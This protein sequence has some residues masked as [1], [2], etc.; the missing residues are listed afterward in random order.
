MA[1]LDKHKDKAEEEFKEPTEVE[2]EDQNEEAENPVETSSDDTQAEEPVA[3]KAQGRFRRL[4]QSR[5]FRIA[6]PIV[7]LV[8]ILA[9]FFVPPVKYA[10]LNLFSNGKAQ[11]VVVDDATLAPVSGAT[12]KVG[13]V[14]GKTDKNG[15]LTLKGLDFGSQTYILTKDSYTTKKA[16]FTVKTGDNLVGPVKVHSDGFAVEVRAVNKLSGAK[17]ADFAV[18]IDGTN[19]SAQS[20]KAGVATLKVPSKRLGKQTLAIT[21]KGFNKLTVET[22]VTADKQVP[23]SASLTLAGKH[24]FL[25]NRDGRMSIYSANLDGSDQTEVIK[26][27]P[28]D[29]TA[30]SFTSSPDGKYGVMLSKRDQIR[31][32][33][34]Q[35][36]SALYAIDYSAKTIK[37]VDEGAPNFSIS[38]WAD[39]TRAV[40]TVDY[41][42]AKRSDNQKIKTVDVTNGKLSTIASFGGYPQIILFREYPQYVYVSLPDPGRPDY[43]LFAYNIN[44]KARTQLESIGIGTFSQYKPGYASYTLDSNGK[45]RDINLKTAKSQDASAPS[46]DSNNL[47]YLPSLDSQKLAWSENRDG[48]GVVIIADRDGANSKQ[49]NSS[50]NAG[51]VIR[52][53]NDDYLIVGSSASNDTAD[54][55][56]DIKTG[57]TTKIS[58]TYRGWYR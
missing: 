31:D 9:G 53:L 34:G 22:V 56:M 15:K 2:Q 19:I 29:D 43:G 3:P 24:Y 52:W 16:D 58:N 1:K 49:V 4:L 10:V 17:M 21:A 18:S 26:G 32:S 45:W 8:L 40:Y 5:K 39:N 12:V 35:V 55:V 47:Y 14:L 6:A 50:L 33:S 46:R 30:T 7:A 54:Y 57:K 11:F 51:G 48:R 36:V 25:S 20:T 44:T 42:D 38:G 28:G 23:I 13:S 37:R 27:A 41:G